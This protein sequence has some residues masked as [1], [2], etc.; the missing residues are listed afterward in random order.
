MRH[1]ALV[2]ALLATTFGNTA[3]A[4]TACE[5]RTLRIWNLL[6]GKLLDTLPT[7]RP[8]KRIFATADNNLVLLDPEGLTC[9]GGSQ[10]A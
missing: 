3:A 9:L 1:P 2:N 4:I 5:D 8:V 6:D 10:N 7:P